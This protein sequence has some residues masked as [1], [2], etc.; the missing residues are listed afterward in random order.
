LHAAAS[1]QAGSPSGGG[2]FSD[3][4][5]T[6]L[7][8]GILNGDLFG[9][10]MAIAPGGLI[11][12]KPVGKP[13]VYMAHGTRDT[14]IPTRISDD[15]AR[16]LRSSGYSVTLRKFRGGHEVPYPISKAAVRWFLRS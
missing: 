14:V 10:V 12:E 1:T 7:S 8:L 13:R 3:G 11:A 5:T 6:A 15:V 16:L 9:T 4:A 2:R